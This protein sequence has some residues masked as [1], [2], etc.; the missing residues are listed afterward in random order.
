G[1]GAPNRFERFEPG[2]P[3]R[4][5]GQNSGGVGGRLY[6]VLGWYAQLLVQFPDHRQSQGTLAVQDLIY[7]VAPADH[8]LQVFRRKAGLLHAE[9]DGLDWVGKVD[10]EVL[11]LIGLNKGGQHV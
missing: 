10:G 8:R 5:D 1:W 11:R 2:W 4:Q 9:L 3:T 7:A 6:Q